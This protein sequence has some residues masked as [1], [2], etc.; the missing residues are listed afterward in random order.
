LPDEA[1]AACFP[2]RE[3]AAVRATLRAAAQRLAARG[4]PEADRRPPLATAGTAEPEPGA[5]LTLYTD[6]AARGNPGP[7]GAGILLLDERGREVAAR[8]ISL[9]ICTNN[10]AEYR[11]LILGLREARRHGAG[12]LSVY[13]DSELIVKQLLGSYQVKDS[14]LKPLH[15]EAAALLETFRFYQI[16]HVPRRD[17]QRA[18]QLANQGIDGGAKP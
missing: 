17:N 3:P 7:A 11:A 1:L 18:D 6:G 12:E 5:R 15:A 2:D 9:G 4:C 13:L 16:L 10:V 14:K 8:G